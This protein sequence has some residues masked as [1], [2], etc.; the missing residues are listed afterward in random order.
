MAKDSNGW[1][2]R[3][4]INP[5]LGGKRCNCSDILTI[6]QARGK[7]KKFLYSM[8][9]NCGTDQRTGTRIQE[10]FKQY[11]TT[12]AELT[13]SEEANQTD[14]KPTLAEPE[15]VPTNNKPTVEPEQTETPTEP[16]PEKKPSAWRVIL[17]GVI[18]GGLTGGAITRLS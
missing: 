4:T 13:A 16:E 14:D 6:H 9:D 7:R 17:T 11:F 2:V 10:R 1:P 18:L 3:K 15:V 5:T 12:M 8:C